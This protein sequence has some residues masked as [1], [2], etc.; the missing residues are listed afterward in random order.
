MTDE[1][2]VRT[3]GAPRTAVSQ[4]HRRGAAWDVASGVRRDRRG[5]CKFDVRICLSARRVRREVVRHE[6]GPLRTPATATQR[7]RC[8]RAAAAD[9]RAPAYVRRT[10]SG[11]AAVF[12]RWRA[13]GC[14]DRLVGRANSFGSV[15]S[16]VQ[17]DPRWGA[18]RLASTVTTSRNGGR[19]LVPTQ[20]VF[21]E[22]PRPTHAVA[23]D[24]RC[25]APE[26]ACGAK[27][28]LTTYLP[29]RY[30]SSGSPVDVVLRAPSTS[31]VSRKAGYHNRERVSS[32]VRASRRH[33]PRCAFNAWYR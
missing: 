11:M 26:L 1:S 19:A 4:G 7:C 27:V 18:D 2:L 8:S 12:T 20:A 5:G 23:G 31:T 14:R 28:A 16:V 15:L 21:F 30:C 32:T 29:H 6:L 22:T 17:R 3:E 25:G 13:A 24:Y 10:A 33:T 9:R